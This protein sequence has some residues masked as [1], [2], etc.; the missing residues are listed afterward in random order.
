M[1]ERQRVERQRVERQRTERQRPEMQKPIRCP[2]SQPAINAGFAAVIAH[3]F[4]SLI[5]IM[6][7]RKEGLSPQPK[8]GWRSIEQVALCNCMYLN[9]YIGMNVERY[10][11]Q[12]R[13]Q[14]ARN[15]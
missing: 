10:V 3:P 5:G 7:I 13:K 15:T 12:A 11:K 2:M 9:P 4:Q 14:F 8:N 1:A 6:V